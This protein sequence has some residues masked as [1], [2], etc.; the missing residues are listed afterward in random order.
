MQ[1]DEKVAKRCSI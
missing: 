1:A